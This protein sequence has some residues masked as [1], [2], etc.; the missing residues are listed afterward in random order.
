MVW[1]GLLLVQVGVLRGIGVVLAMLFLLSQVVVE[2]Q[3]GQYSHLMMT[4]L[5][6]LCFPVMESIV[7]IIV[8]VVFSNCGGILE[9]KLVDFVFPIEVWEA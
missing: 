1:L 4:C 5:R 6:I 8:S 3:V 2:L 9:L 7:K